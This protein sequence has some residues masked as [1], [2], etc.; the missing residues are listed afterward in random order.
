MKGYGSRT[1]TVILVDELNNVDF[2]EVTMATPD[3]NGEWVTT[4]LQS[5]L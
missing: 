4:R 5:Q 1:H 2:I 3:P